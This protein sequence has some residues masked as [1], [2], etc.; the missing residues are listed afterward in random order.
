MGGGGGLAQSDAHNP[1]RSVD[2]SSIW[3]SPAQP[4]LQCRSANAK[5]SWY[6]QMWSKNPTQERCHKAAGPFQVDLDADLGLGGLAADLRLAHGPVVPCPARRGLYGFGRAPAKHLAVAIL[7]SGG[8]AANTTRGQSRF[9]LSKAARPRAA[10]PMLSPHFYRVPHS[11]K[12]FSMIRLPLKPFRCA[13][14]LASPAPRWRH[15]A[16]RVTMANR[17]ITPAQPGR[18]QRI[19]PSCRRGRHFEGGE[20]PG[21]GRRVTTLSVNGNPVPIGGRPSDRDRYQ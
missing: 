12:V 19:S 9:P 20:P 4:H 18:Q 11:G 10:C 5:K 21:R 13:W 1:R 15:P 6:Q 8:A 7:P 2:G 17:T 3:V 16:N 14:R